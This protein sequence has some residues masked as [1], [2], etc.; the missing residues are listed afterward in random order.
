[1]ILVRCAAGL[2]WQDEGM[3]WLA[4]GELLVV[5]TE[6]DWF[7]GSVELRAEVL[8]VRSGLRGHPTSV[9]HEDV[10]RIVPYGEFGD[11]LV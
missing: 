7:L 3:G 5:E 4:G 11:A 1:M 10:V 6:D 9:P 2:A 8:V